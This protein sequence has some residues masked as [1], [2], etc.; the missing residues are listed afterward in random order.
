MSQLYTISINVV[1]TDIFRTNSNYLDSRWKLLDLSN[2][3]LS[4]EFVTEIISTVNWEEIG[5]TANYIKN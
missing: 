1:T 5:W 3:F 2:N 4:Y